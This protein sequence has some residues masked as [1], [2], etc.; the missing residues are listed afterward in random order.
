MSLPP[1]IIKSENHSSPAYPPNDDAVYL[2]NFL[3][4]IDAFKVGNTRATDTL[5]SDLMY[6]YALA[7]DNKTTDTRVDAKITT[8][9]Y[10]RI[11]NLKSKTKKYGF[12]HL[13]AQFLH[14]IFTNATSEEWGNK[15]SP[16]RLATENINNILKELSMGETS[17]PEHVP[18]YYQFR[19][20]LD[21]HADKSSFSIE[22][23]EP[24][25]KSFSSASEDAIIPRL[26]DTHKA[27]KS[28]TDV[29]ILIQN[30]S[31]QNNQVLVFYTS[32][33][34]LEIEQENETNIFDVMLVR[35]I[36][37]SKKD[38]R[39]NHA[40]GN[41]FRINPNSG[42]YCLYAIGV[43]DNWDLNEELG[44]QLKEDAVL[45]GNQNQLLISALKEKLKNNPND[46]QIA[47]HPYRI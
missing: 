21:A 17:W 29:Q 25:T 47:S 3:K 20:V 9:G 35:H 28:G 13:E 44:F 22:F 32:E 34:S 45:L 2:L 14:T 19:S 15:V 42:K 26:K 12:K 5:L 27:Y 46:I 11:G 6:E 4:F 30:V 24:S 7:E 18:A 39:L 37:N 1:K 16:E 43:S 38:I 10:N 40:D 41:Y 36:R 33:E 23:S 8:Y 31:Q